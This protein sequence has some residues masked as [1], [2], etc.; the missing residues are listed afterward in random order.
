ML[1]YRNKNLSKYDLL[2][3][4][5]Q[6]DSLTKG[7]LESIESVSFSYNKI[8][9]E[10][11][12]H[13]MQALPTTVRILGLVDCNLNDDGGMAVLEWVKK[14]ELLQMLCIEENKFSI[15]LKN[16]FTVLSKTR[17]DFSLYI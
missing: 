14:N 2:K 17:T 7:E 4:F 6:I 10:N 12:A 5:E 8:D 1:N 15:Y 3:V 13:L 9:T 16:E 11:I